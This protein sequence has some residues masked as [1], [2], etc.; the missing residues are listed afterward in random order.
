MELTD[1]LL[2]VGGEKVASWK[3][4]SVV[5]AVTLNF[6]GKDIKPDTL[7]SEKGTLKLTVENAVSKTTK[8]ITLTDEAIKGLN[9]LPQ[10]KVDQEVDLLKGLTFAEGFELVKVELETEGKSS[11]IADPAH[12]TPAYP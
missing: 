9:K 8:T 12:F 6:N 11:E 4:A 7:L 5:K 1:S 10:L 3:S 2:L